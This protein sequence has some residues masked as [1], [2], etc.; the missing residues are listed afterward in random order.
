M[1]ELFDWNVGMSGIAVILLIAGALVLGAV[2]LFVGE[3]K[4][5]YEWLV[6]AAAVLVGGWLGSEAFGSLSTF[7]PAF[8]G[9]YLVTALIGG[10]VLGVVVDAAVRYMTGGSYTHAPRPV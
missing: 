7:G 10:I 8:D 6:S 3:P 1:L 4:T 5:G 2:P 9:L